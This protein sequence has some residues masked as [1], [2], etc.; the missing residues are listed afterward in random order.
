MMSESTLHR[1]VKVLRNF[2]GIDSAEDDGDCVAIT[3]GGRDGEVAELVWQRVAERFNL[4]RTDGGWIVDAAQAKGCLR[5]VAYASAD[6]FSNP[7]FAP[8]RDGGKDVAA[9]NL[10]NRLARAWHVMEARIEERA[11][12]PFNVWANA[13]RVLSEQPIQQSEFVERVVLADRAVRVVL[14]DLDGLG[15]VTLEGGGKHRRI[16]LT[17]EG[18]RAKRQVESAIQT[19]VDT[20]DEGDDG[21]T[22]LRRCLAACIAPMA[23]ELPWG[24]TGYGLGDSSLTGGRNIEARSTPNFL[25][26]HGEEWPV[27]S[28]EPGDAPK[29]HPLPALLAKALARFVIDYEHKNLG[30]V[31]GASATRGFPDEGLPMADAKARFGITGAGRSGPERHFYIV[32]PIG[33]AKSRRAYLTPKGKRERDALGWTSSCVEADWR[34]ELGEAVVDDLGAALESIASAAGES[35][36]DLRPSQWFSRLHSLNQ[37]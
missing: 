8:A 13:L 14:R 31:I 22:K 29:D 32:T 23:Y 5:V 34:A 11:G 33:T 6:H 4:E 1:L 7:G 9:N 36:V 20:F 10:F 17:P 35:D 18:R 24:F 21:A 19:V 2:D 3:F 15:W 30:S 28:R 26:A 25:P 37:R 12:I 16:G 27:V